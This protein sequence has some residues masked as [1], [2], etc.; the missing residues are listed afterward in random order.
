MLV[1]L[2]QHR[3]ALSTS[4]GDPRTSAIPGQELPKFIFHNE[5]VRFRFILF[6]LVIFYNINT[7]IFI[8]FF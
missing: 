3:L 2:E 6:F 5:Q 7:T 8:G 4:F 1:G